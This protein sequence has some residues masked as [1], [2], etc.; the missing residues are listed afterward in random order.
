M[1]QE[2]RCDVFAVA[3][4]AEDI[5]CSLLCLFLCVQGSSLP[6]P[7][8]WALFSES[9]LAAL[10]MPPWP[11]SSLQH[12]YSRAE[13]I[14]HAEIGPHV[15]TVSRCV[16]QSCLGSD[17][18]FSPNKQQPLMR[19]HLCPPPAPCCLVTSKLQSEERRVL[20]QQ[21]SALNDAKPAATS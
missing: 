18:L 5:H 19:R 2:I 13:C 21:K 15:L 20:I 10:L 4:A 7:E 8:H 1:W 11:G 14:H 12:R 17:L 16:T 3:C 9:K 6:K